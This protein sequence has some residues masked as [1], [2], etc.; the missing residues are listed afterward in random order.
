MYL[1]KIRSYF[2]SVGTLTK[3]E[4]YAV[5]DAV[6]TMEQGNMASLGLHDEP[7]HGK[8]K[9]FRSCRANQD[10]RVIY[11]PFGDEGV[12]CYAGH[13]EKAYDWAERHKCAQNPTTH[14]VQVYEDVA[15]QTTA[16][17]ATTAALPP[18]G[19]R[20]N[21]FLAWPS[22]DDLMTLGVPADQL[23][24]VRGIKN[25]DDLAEKGAA[26]VMPD[27][28]WNILVDL[29][30][31]P[32]K[33]TDHLATAK[34]AAAALGT[35]ATLSQQAAVNANANG[36]F[37]FLSGDE[38]LNRMRA[39]ALDAWRVFLHPEQLSVVNRNFNGPVKV[40]GGA[41]TGKTVVAIHRV[42]WLLEN[43]FADTEG[44]ILLTTFTNTLAGD[45]KR[46]LADICTPAQMACVD[47]QTLDK[48]AQALLKAGGV[49]VKID[50]DRELDRSRQYMTPSMSAVGYAGKRKVSFFLDE[51]EQVVEADGI[52]TEEAYLAANRSGRSVPLSTEERKQLWPV[53]VKFREL[54]VNSGQVRRGEAFNKATAQLL[55]GGESPYLAV[56]VDEVQDLDAPALRL[57]AALSGNS[58]TVAKPN[59]LMLVGDAH[60]RIY[61]R[62]VSLAACGIQTKGRSKTLKMNYRSTQK[63]RLRAESI[64]AGVPVD[65]L[66]GGTTSLRGGRSLVLGKAPDEKRFVN[67][68]DMAKGI[69]ATVK[70]W[71]DADNANAEEGSEKTYSDYAILL[72]SN[73]EVD[74]MIQALSVTWLP[75]E[76]VIGEGKSVSSDPA[77]RVMTLHRAKGLEFSGVVL[78]AS[79]GKWPRKPTGFDSLP[80]PEKV[81]LLA[82]EKSLLYVGMTRAISHVLLTGLGEAPDEL[83][84]GVSAQPV[85][86]I[87]VTQ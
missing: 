44:K 16:P 33:L 19:D 5:W 37:S 65:D 82:R 10:I 63:I 76:K 80:D 71:M 26:G 36:P 54:F 31:E 43:C 7:L 15:A 61:G 23:A 18:A 64:L 85:D 14:M 20:P 41:G 81:T 69:E 87:E 84:P 75:A 83:N 34:A 47:V 9:G 8:G 48:T 68:I 6:N 46:L 21:P 72:P 12:L 2:D 56:V 74:K 50:Y 55:S 42:K 40:I 60:Q 58:A 77:V 1:A 17:V 59:S 3:D 49:N 32:S 22:D 79:Q 13:H 70:A 51:Y 11:V 66:D 86:T 78:V 57:V 35:N 45:L 53:F 52:E 38:L 25:E 28:I 67:E 27:N 62:R 39:G 30:D 4:R 29:I 24:F 73:G